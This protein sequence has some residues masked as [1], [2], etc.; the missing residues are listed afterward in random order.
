MAGLPRPDVMRTAGSRPGQ[1]RRNPGLTRRDLLWRGAAGAGLLAASPVLAACSSGTAT[2]SASASA[3]T[4]KRGGTLSFGRQT[5]P[6]QLDPANSIVEGD[7]YTWTRSSS[8]STS[9]ARRASFC[10]GSL[11]ATRSAPTARPGPSR[12]ARG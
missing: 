12:C 2:S 6:T 11:R 9:P 4:P 1:A 7:V 10:P 3:G 5:G 8:R